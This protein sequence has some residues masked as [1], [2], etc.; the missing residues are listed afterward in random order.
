MFLNV[1]GA[2]IVKGARYHIVERRTKLFRLFFD[3]DAHVA[4]DAP[5]VEWRPIVELIALTVSE[6]FDSESPDVC[7]A[8]APERQ[9]TSGDDK[10]RKFGFHLHF[11]TIRVGSPVA[12]VVR[13]SVIETLEKEFPGVVAN[14]WPSC[15]DEAVFNGS[16]LRLP[17][18]RKGPSASPENVYAPWLERKSGEW[19]ELDA[20][21]VLKSVKLTRA[22]L[23]TC[24]LRCGPNES[25]TPLSR[26]T[27]SEEELAALNERDDS[28]AASNALVGA[29]HVSLSKFSSA[30]PALQACLPP[31]YADQKFTAV[32]ETDTVFLIRSSSKFCQ[33]VGREHGSSNVYFVLRPG[34]V[35]QHCYC[36]KG[37]LEGRSSGKTCKDF[38]GRIHHVPPIVTGHFFGSKFVDDC[39]IAEHP[40][41]GVQKTREIIAAQI[42]KEASEMRKR[43]MPSEFT[44]R[45]SSVGGMLARMTSAN[46]KPSKKRKKP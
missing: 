10:R 19:T 43:M 34:G 21:T 44:K 17:W 32:L 24:S 42:E 20:S 15:V 23:S 36:R 6:M 11:P 38:A 3:L 45:S 1:L 28:G 9:I 31:E 26:G 37:D 16:G 33:N 14:G 40:E 8:R 35:S 22:V 41:H 12:L 39:P 29:K 27:I 5:D 18:Q 46:A 30:L 4:I 2:D 7:V 25:A 13:R